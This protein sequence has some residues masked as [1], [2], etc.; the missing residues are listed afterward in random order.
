MIHNL[1]YI[2]HLKKRKYINEKEM[3]RYIAGMDI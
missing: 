1:P 3:L 2:L